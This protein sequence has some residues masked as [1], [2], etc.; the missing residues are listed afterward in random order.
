MVTGNNT[1]STRLEAVSSAIENT[2]AEHG[3]LSIY[4]SVDGLS[5]SLLDRAHNRVVLLAEYDIPDTPSAAL[6]LLSQFDV[7]FSKYRLS[8]SC[9]EATW[10]PAPLYDEASA[11]TLAKIT[12]GKGDLT[13]FTFESLDSVLLCTPPTAVIEGLSAQL[14]NASLWPAPAVSAISL[15]RHWKNRPGVHACATLL[16]KEL[17]ITVFDNGKLA[18]NNQYSAQTDQDRL[19][20][21]LFAYE[22]LK[23]NPE[24]VPLKVNGHIIKGN[25]LWKLLEKYVRDVDILSSASTL[26]FAPE[27][28]SSEAAK[29]PF[30]LDLFS[31]E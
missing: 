6:E 23:L 7:S 20:Y 13:A 14:P 28:P 8:W 12:T 11:S 3:E 1:I 19:Y 17:V 29:R 24:E 18:L 21:I 9:T 4:H 30:T 27:I 26:Q 15:Q 2:S 16:D 22:V 31:C 25:T 10:V 5:F